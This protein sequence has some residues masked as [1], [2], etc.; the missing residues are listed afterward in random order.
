MKRVL[1]IVG[2]FLLIFVLFCVGA[3]AE[4]GSLSCT[5][6]DLGCDNAEHKVAVCGGNMCGF[7]CE[8]ESQTCE[9]FPLWFGLDQTQS[10]FQPVLG[11]IGV[12]SC[13]PIGSGGAFSPD[14]S[15]PEGNEIPVK[16][17]VEP[18]KEEDYT[19]NYITYTI[20]DDVSGERFS[21]GNFSELLASEVFEDLRLKSYF[22]LDYTSTFSFYVEINLDVECAVDL[23]ATANLNI[24]IYSNAITGERP[25][26][27]TFTT[28]IHLSAGE[29]QTVGISMSD[30]ELIYAQRT[31][32]LS[33]SE[34]TYSGTKT[35][36]MRGDGK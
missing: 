4:C 32:D 19:V 31:W 35:Q 3:S 16:K 25:T 11:G 20:R 14:D 8:G 9:W 1:I 15:A 13:G 12:C 18:L 27:K 36:Y 28:K 22:D 23:E 33:I 17:V 7:R 29:G 30:I 24:D 5:R 2:I 26:Q 6:A 21:S 34:V 10:C